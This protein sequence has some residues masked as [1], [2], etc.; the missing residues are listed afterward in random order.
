MREV[1]WGILGF[2]ILY[3]VLPFLWTRLL[4]IG[5]LKRSPTPKR[6]YF[7]FDDGPDPLYTP[8]L[9]ELLDRYGVKATFFVIGERAE[10][11]PELIRLIH[12]RGHAIGIHNRFHNPN[13][14]INP[15]RLRRD[16]D[17]TAAFIE[18]VTGE[19][20]RFYRPPW[21][22]LSFADL[23]LL[24]SYTIVIWSFMGWDWG[25]KTTP[26]GLKRRMLKGIRGGDVVLLHDC[27]QTAG[28]DPKAPERMMAALEETLR[29]ICDSG[30][31]Y[32]SLNNV[33][34]DY[35]HMRP[36]TIPLWKR[37]LARFVLKLDDLIRL[38]I[39]VHPLERRD[40]FLYG[41]VI[42]YHGQP[43]QL[44]N[45]EIIQNGDELLEIHL[46]NALLFQL[47]SHSRSTMRW[48]VELIHALEDFLPV[49][50]K[51]VMT[52]PRY[53][54]V[55]GLYGVTLVNRGIKPFGFE[56]FDLPEGLFTRLSR[57]YLRFFMFSIHPHGK[58]RLETKTELLIPK[59]IFMSRKVL[60]DRYGQK[61]AFSP[62]PHSMSVS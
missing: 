39:G 14:F 27:G 49:V 53:R 12:E 41:R 34:E 9:L 18:S 50:A 36:F 28:A 37:G 23:F 3:M 7:T 26:E 48:M 22:I 30:Y 55:K 15:F 38:L 13:W 10:K 45:G 42:R 40:G 35:A 6:I 2:V 20:P 17:D 54:N 56:V 24:R 52:Q 59:M 43:V 11:H 1:G 19:R 44:E 47:G 21:G 32:L 57:I 46:N 33:K 60:V 51:I 58:E 31:L 5:V 16:L 8:K 25:K 29:E 61:D 4:G 62:L